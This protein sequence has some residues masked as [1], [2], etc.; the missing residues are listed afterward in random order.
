M[1]NS[2]S[3]LDSIIIA[4]YFLSVAG[5]GLFVTRKEKNA[6]TYFLAGRSLGWLAVGASLFFAFI[7]LEILIWLTNSRPFFPSVIW[8]TLGM[9][10]ALGF[11]IGPIY[12]KK[13][14]ST[15]PEFLES[16]ISKTGR[17]YVSIILIL[18]GILSRNILTLYAARIFLLQLTRQDVDTFMILIVVV[19]G[20]YTVVGGLKAV[21]YTQLAQAGFFLAAVLLVLINR[22]GV[23][24]GLVD[25][26]FI[27]PIK[28]ID[29][30]PESGLRFSSTLLGF[31]IAILGYWIAD[32]YVIQRVLA[33]KNI[34][35]VK[36]GALLA[37]LVKLFVFLLFVP[38][39]IKLFRADKTP[40]ES[41]TGM[42][43]GNLS[44]S[45][46][47]AGLIIAGL[48]AA[49]MT[50][51]ASS[52]NSSATLYALDFYR[53]LHPRTSDRQLVLVGR[54]TA[55]ALVMLTIFW[56]PFMP[57]L[58]WQVLVYLLLIPIYLIIPVVA[59]FIISRFRPE[60]LKPGA[61]WVLVTT[62]GFGI[63]FLI[64]KIWVQSGGLNSP[65]L[66][67]MADLNVFQMMLVL[68]LASICLFLVLNLKAKALA[69]FW[70]DK[71]TLANFLKK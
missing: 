27:A 31:M 13:A 44:N 21:L 62:S 19:A 1:I 56:I 58:T 25:V 69:A 36:K 55:T 47:M 3:Q 37:V 70:L 35:Q 53:H 42:I 9:I 67:R 6:L 52:F 43:I 65:I 39:F 59:L 34:Q 57:L 5:I 64:I 51:L 14:V 40:I 45:D 4:F 23:T 2:L 12:L 11:C 17:F 7:D 49:L 18:T 28:I 60:N 50:V 54:L 30:N 29:L 8:L 32:Q 48:L 68:F 71:K 61:F 66:R 16:Y 20:I 63:V 41:F 24:W 10:L 15:I 38:G 26:N 22:S 46:G 33:A